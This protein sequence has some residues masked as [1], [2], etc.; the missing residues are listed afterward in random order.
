[1]RKED[2][3]EEVLAAARNGE[4]WAV[5]A[6]WRTFQPPLLRYLRG[7][8]GGSAED[9]ASETWLSVGDSLPRFRGD[10]NGFRAWLFTLGRRRAIDHSRRAARAPISVDRIPEARGED[11]VEDEFARSE[12][13]ALTLHY[14]SLLPLE[15]REVVLLRTVGGFDVEQVASIMDKRAGTVRVIHHRALKQLAQAVRANRVTQEGG[16]SISDDEDLFAA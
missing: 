4:E 15:Q 2:S 8:C 5:G 11:V 3:F 12:A 1:V 7:V 10:E 14:L 6:L 9:A 16:G 13:L